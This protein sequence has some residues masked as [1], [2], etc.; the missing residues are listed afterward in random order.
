MSG[1]GQ[2]GGCELGWE[3]SGVWS[4][5]ERSAVSAAGRGWNCCLHPEPISDALV[6]SQG[7][8]FWDRVEDRGSLSPQAINGIQ[9]QNKVRNSPS[10]GPDRSNFTLELDFL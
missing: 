4:S 7:L 8:E 6:C 1:V 10:C 2:G 9:T 5:L 3:G